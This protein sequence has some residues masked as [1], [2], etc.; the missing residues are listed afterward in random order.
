MRQPDDNQPI[1]RIMENLNNDPNT[2]QWENYQFENEY[3]V[4]ADLV[5]AR[6]PTPKKSEA[7]LPDV[8]G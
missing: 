8:D 1:E 5:K 7:S 6:R 2:V 4:P 3:N